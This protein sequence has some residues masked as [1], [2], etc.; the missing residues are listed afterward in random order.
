MQNGSYIF[1]LV[2]AHAHTILASFS[3]QDFFLTSSSQS[4]K[5]DGHCATGLRS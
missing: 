4:I 3:L 5:S 1:H 2:L